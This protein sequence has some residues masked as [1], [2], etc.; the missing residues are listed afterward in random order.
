MRQWNHTLSVSLLI[1]RQGLSNIF[2]YRTNFF[3]RI[4]GGFLSFLFLVSIWQA[5][6]PQDFSSTFWMFYVL[7]GIIG[8][9]TGE[10]FYHQMAAEINQGQL[11]YFLLQPFGYFPRKVSKLFADSLV[12]AAVS[13]VVI[14]ITAIFVKGIFVVSWQNILLMIPFLILGKVIGILT[15]FLAGCI[16]FIWIQPEAFYLVLDGILG[17][18]YGGLVPFWVLSENWQKVLLLFPFRSVIATPTEIA[19]GVTAG[20]DQKLLSSTL[21][22][23]IMVLASFNIWKKVSIHYEAVG[24]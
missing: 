11:S 14:C 1:F 22:A 18:L 12:S 5:L 21:W 15:S 9:F 2:E 7:A 10:G 20:I 13:L 17:A 6:R 19:I 16:S 23:I 4:L 3:L 8:A 24:G